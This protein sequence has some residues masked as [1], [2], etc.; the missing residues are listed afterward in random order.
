MIK[1]MNLLKD[2]LNIIGYFRK[3]YMI[4]FFYFLVHKTR[5]MFLDSI[6][7]IPSQI[8]ST[9]GGLLNNLISI[10]GQLVGTVTS[11]IG[12]TI[13][14]VSNVAGNTIGSVANS[15]ANTVQG[16][17]SSATNLLSSPVV[18]IGVGIVLVILLK[19]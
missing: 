14:A 2:Y 16:V 10:P 13:G 11:S 17:A 5:E 1:T 15:A 7:G 9:T 8:I 3:Q 18:I 6:L 12:G 19:K 4:T